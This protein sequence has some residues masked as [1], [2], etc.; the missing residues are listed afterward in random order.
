MAHK[1]LLQ[2]PEWEVLHKDVVVKVT[3]DDGKLGEIHLSKGSIE[4]VPSG[5]HVNRKK[6]S[7]ADFADLMEEHGKDKRR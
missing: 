5:H 4:W 2:Q 6:M 3:G 1:I 7:W